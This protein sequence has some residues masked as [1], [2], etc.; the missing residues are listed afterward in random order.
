MYS[1][2]GDT[3]DWYGTDKYDFDPAHR[4]DRERDAARAGAA[5]PRTYEEKRSPLE[6]LV[7]P[8]RAIESSSKTPIVVAV[9]VTGSMARWPFE[10]FDRLPLLYMT[11]HQ[12][13]PE[14]EI[15]FAAIGD[16]RYDRYPLQVTSFAKGYDLE[17]QLKALF[18]EGGGGDGPEGYGLFAWY[19][20]NRVS[21]PNATEPPF[22]IV[23][24]DAPMHETVHAKEIAK[25]CG[26]SSQDQNAIELWKAVA[27]KYNTWFLR[28]P[29]GSAGDEVDQQWFRAL[30]PQQVARVHDEARAIDYA[31]G[32]VARSWGR[33]EDF[34]KNMAARHAKEKVDE[35]AKRIVEEVKPKVLHCP[36]CMASLPPTAFGRWVCE[37][38][39]ATLDL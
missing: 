27:K 24:G 37:Y 3:S 17:Q 9:D 31:L 25:V 12:Y 22:L 19:M 2:S 32:I 15:C 5:G 13:R 35:L 18:G 39:K 14:L 7:D 36:N 11:L 1:W 4:A 29:T 8:K 30:G 34:K 23:Y 38:C 28:R 16:A 26:V 10:I 21:I 33:F 6:A 20:L